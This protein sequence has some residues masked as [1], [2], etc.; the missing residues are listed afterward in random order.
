MT[1]RQTNSY[2]IDNVYFDIHLWTLQSLI[3]DTC[4]LLQ[5]MLD[6][7]TSAEA[8]GKNVGSFRQLIHENPL[9]VEEL[10]NLIE[11]TQNL[12]L[13]R[14]LHELAMWAYFDEQSDLC[15]GS[16]SIKMHRFEDI[17]ID[18]EEADE[19]NQDTP[20]LFELQPY[21]PSPKRSALNIPLEPQDEVWEMDFI[22]FY[23]VYDDQITNEMS[24]QV[25]LIGCID[26]LKMIEHLETIEQL[27]K[28]IL[29]KTNLRLALYLSTFFGFMIHSVEV[30][31]DE[32]S[33][34]EAKKVNLT[35]ISSVEFIRDFIAKYKT[36]TKRQKVKKGHEATVYVGVSGGDPADE[37]Y[38]YGVEP[39]DIE[40]TIAIPTTVLMTKKR[41]LTDLLQRTAIQL[42]R[43][44]Q[45]SPESAEITAR[46]QA[47]G[48]IIKEI[49]ETQDEE[50]E[51]S[52]LTRLHS[53]LSR[54]L[55]FLAP[56]LE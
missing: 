13:L 22:P 32:D 1:E 33:Q 42:S 48:T 20:F 53:Y 16:V 27:P 52:L 25:Q 23:N 56:K 29:G 8:R 39:V 10:E 12:H 47:L 46:K 6:E 41:L 2:I 5:E 45:T 14:T 11:K 36:V 35:P 3:P 7:I 26:M 51:E 30:E 44:F 40:V 37:A 15:I 21:L 43:Q 38:E 50:S 31:Y 24:Y 19:N 18:E 49:I 17:F 34:G 28:I 9:L 55:L 54:L 4:P